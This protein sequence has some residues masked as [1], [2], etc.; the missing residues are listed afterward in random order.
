MLIRLVKVECLLTT[1]A[2]EVIHYYISIFREPEINLSI[3]I[4]SIEIR[5]ERQTAFHTTTINAAHHQ[6]QRDLENWT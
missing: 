5:G 1:L 2:A 6:T 4:I 3:G